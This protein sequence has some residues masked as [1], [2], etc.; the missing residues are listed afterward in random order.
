MQNKA[1]Y[2]L[3][4]ENGKISPLSSENVGKYEFLTSED[5]LQEKGILEKAA[6][7]KRFKYS[8]L[9]NELKKT[10]NKWILQKI[11]ISFLK[12]KCY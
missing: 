11:N 2:N 3:G 1:Q 4:G 5:V 9:S 7:I 10:K 12:I 6:T 8:P